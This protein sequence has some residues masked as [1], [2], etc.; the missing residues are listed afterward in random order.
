[1]KKFY[2]LFPNHLNGLKLN[3]I[4]VKERIQNIISPTPRKI[5]SCC[6]MSLM[7]RE[8]DLPEIKRIISREKI[9]VLKIGCLD[10][11]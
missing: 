8:T 1:M 4:L 10:D 5:S 9:E 3:S 2:I 6:G 7:V 11:D